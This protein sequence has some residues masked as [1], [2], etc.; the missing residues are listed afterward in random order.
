MSAAVGTDSRVRSDTLHKV[1]SRAGDPLAVCIDCRFVTSVPYPC[2]LMARVASGCVAPDSGPGETCRHQKDSL[3]LPLIFD[4]S[5]TAAL[6]GFLHQSSS[7]C[8]A[9]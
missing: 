9:P 7:L 1:F 6:P 2:H 5:T 8:L 3:D 4:C